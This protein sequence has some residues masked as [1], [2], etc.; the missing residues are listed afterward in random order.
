MKTVG[1]ITEYNP[2]HN[3][4]KYHIDE[5]RRLSGADY[6]IVVMSG[7]FVQ[8]GAPSVIDKY[9]RTEMALRNGVDLV[10]ELPVCYATGSAEFFA[11]GAVSLLHKLGI[12]DYLCFGSESGDISLLMEA[13]KYLIDV[14]KSYD[15]SIQSYLKEGL[16]YPAA[17]LKAITES[18]NET[19][20]ANVQ[21]L[22]KV[23]SEPNNI[24][25]I[26]YLKA[27][28]HF[29]SN[30]S[31]LTIKRISNHYHDINLADELAEPDLSLT[32]K[33]FVD[34]QFPNKMLISSATAIRRAMV[35]ETQDI[36]D[37]FKKMKSS[38]PD[39]VYQ[40]LQ[41]NY[42]KTFPIT[43]EDFS[44]LFKY[45]LLT[46]DKNALTSYLD[47]TGDLADRLKKIPNFNQ[48]I[49]NLAQ[50][51][52]TKNMTLTRI[53]RA[54]IH[55]LLNI[56][57]ENVKNYNTA[58][59]TQYARILGL[60]KQS[61]PLLTYIEKT[62]KLPIITKVSKAD[63]Q[64]TS[65]GLQMLSEDITAAHLYHQAVYEKFKTPVS[66][67]YRHGLVIV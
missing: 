16:T 57:T 58:G 12:V 23:L 3:G 56:R 38:V 25:G 32:S 53:N 37:S 47:I 14:P 8:R 51:I 35:Q 21:S 41:S 44:I 13:A 34:N 67:E 5:A 52:K 10:L 24:L 66:S 33:Q 17:R 50:S 20:I 30:I 9:L 49:S 27:L 29:R 1:L 63:K 40:I 7:D 64:L 15:N 45:K 18:F 36:H 28:L 6:V 43:E 62:S 22:T 54:L 26:E 61:S 19:G 4:H 48:T 2:F 31:P 42:L 65:L 59:Y 60:K 11:Y 46:E 39:E 55:L